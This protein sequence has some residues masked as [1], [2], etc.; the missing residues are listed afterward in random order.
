V[1]EF[2][3]VQCQGAT[4]DHRYQIIAR[5][6]SRFRENSVYQMTAAKSHATLKQP[7]IERVMHAREIHT[8]NNKSL[9]LRGTE[10]QLQFQR[11]R[12]KSVCR[13]DGGRR[14]TFL[15]APLFFQMSERNRWKSKNTNHRVDANLRNE[16]IGNG[17]PAGR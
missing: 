5:F 16:L 10:L 7:V 1:T 13:T 9:R 4:G 2:G 15:V 14:V 11:P 17:T 12:S 3:H 6:Q 8:K